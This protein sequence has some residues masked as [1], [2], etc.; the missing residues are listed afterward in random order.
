MVSTEITTTEGCYAFKNHNMVWRIRRTLLFHV[1][2]GYLLTIV[3]DGILKI[4]VLI[5]FLAEEM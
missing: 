1:V 2:F 4:S 5:M 3:W